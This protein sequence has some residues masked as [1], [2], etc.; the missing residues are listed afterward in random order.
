LTPSATLGRPTEITSQAYNSPS[1]KRQKQV[2]L[3]LSN[4]YVNC[5][6]DTARICCWVPSECS[7][8]ADGVRTALSR[9]PAARRAA[10]AW[11]DRQTDGRTQDHAI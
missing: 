4:S 2:W 9:K 3:Q 1:S 5:E 8:A 10:V 11:W 6:R 7:S